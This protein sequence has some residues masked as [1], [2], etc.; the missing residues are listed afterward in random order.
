MDGVDPPSQLRTT[1][2][3]GGGN[4][5]GRGLIFNLPI[6]IAIALVVMI[7]TTSYRQVV[8]GYP[9]GCYTVARANLGVVF[10]LIE[11]GALL[12]AACLVQGLLV[13]ARWRRSACLARCHR[14]DRQHGGLTVRPRCQQCGQAFNGDIR[15]HVARVI[16]IE[17]RDLMGKGQDV[18]ELLLRQV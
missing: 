10:G 9:G 1:R 14:P 4:V 13:G 8:R 15:G 16:K 2:C 12:I 18:R 3:G 5:R 11:A 17:A 7:L 6:D